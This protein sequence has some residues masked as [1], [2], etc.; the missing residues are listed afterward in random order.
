MNLNL[1]SLLFCLIIASL[2][3]ASDLIAQN[4]VPSGINYQAIARNGAGSVY[5]NQ[6]IGVRISILQ[7]TN[8]GVIQYTE[9]HTA[10][11]NVFG[12]FTLKIGGGTPLTGAFSDITWNTANQYV[13]VEVDPTGG[14]NYTDLGS[15]ELLSVPYAFYAQSSGTGGAP[16]REPASGLRP[17]LPPPGTTG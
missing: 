13:K 3:G 17:R 4:P 14:T 2:L 12:L 10:T 1:P 11:T 16:I 7:G 9:R 8:P 5:F 15:N 6:D